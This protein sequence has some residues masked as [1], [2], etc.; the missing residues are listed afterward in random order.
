MR[1]GLDLALVA[2]DLAVAVVGG[3]LVAAELDARVARDV[4]LE[5]HLEN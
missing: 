3:L 5:V 4:E 2:E 1:G